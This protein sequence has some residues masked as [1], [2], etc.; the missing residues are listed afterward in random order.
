VKCEYGCNQEASFQ[1]KS[2]KWCCSKSPSSCSVIKYKNSLAIKQA[3]KE[4]RIKTT[5]LDGKRAW[6]KNKDEK[7]VKKIRER[8]GKTYSNNK[9]KGL[10]KE[11]LGGFKNIKYYSIFCQY[12]NQQIKVHGNWEFSYAKYLN[13]N[14]II[15][16]NRKYLDY[17]DKIGKMHVY[18]PDFYL[19]DKN[20]YIEIKGKWKIIGK[21]SQEKMDYVR[22]S[23][24]NEK[25]IILRYEDLKQLKI[26]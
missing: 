11:N 4:G 17:H 22:N 24:P 15:W 26:L 16:T 23:N 20:E 6:W 1:L 21:D 5:Q 12:L 7:E 14:N 13:D 3:H 18:Y 9:K 19:I 10:H 8:Q 2:G 25:I